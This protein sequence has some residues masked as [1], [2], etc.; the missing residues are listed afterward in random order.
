M[1]TDKAT[2][3]QGVHSRRTRAKIFRVFLI[4]AVLCVIVA[5]VLLLDNFVTAWSALLGGGLYLIPNLYFAHRALAFRDKQSAG[6]ALAEMYVSQIWKM[7]ISILGFSAVFI[8][9]QPLNP[10]SLFGTFILMQISAWF[11]Q[12]KLNNRF[13]K[14]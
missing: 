14:L 5:A 4:Q 12:M 13:L 9:I 1:T 3:K 8:L 11:A 6:R 7:G 2:P 10:F